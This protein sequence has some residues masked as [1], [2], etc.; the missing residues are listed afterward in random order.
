MEKKWGK[1]VR[2]FKYKGKKVELLF[3]YCSNYMR[4]KNYGNWKYRVYPETKWRALKNTAGG[5]MTL[6]RST[7]IVGIE[8]EIKRK[9]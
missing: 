2:G 1:R 7:A 5:Y 8:E 3:R 9:R 6:L 4:W